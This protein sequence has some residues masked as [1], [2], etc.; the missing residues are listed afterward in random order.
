MLRRLVR[1]VRLQAVDHLGNLTASHRLIKATNAHRDSILVREHHDVDGVPAMIIRIVLLHADL[2]DARHELCSLH[3]GDVAGG[4]EVTVRKAVDDA[5][6]LGVADVEP[7][8]IVVRNVCIEG[9]AGLHAGRA[10]IVAVTH[11][12]LTGHQLHQFIAAHA[13]VRMVSA[14]CVV[15][16][17]IVVR[18]QVLDGLIIGT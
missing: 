11:E 17:E 6:C 10:G 9:V 18:P 14:G 2:Q 1:R 4:A 13:S 5:T 15:T 12:E 3:E 7:V 8:R 16:S